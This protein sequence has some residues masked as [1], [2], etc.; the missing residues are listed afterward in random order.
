[1][2]ELSVEYR[3]ILVLREIEGWS[4]K[5]LASGLKLPPGTVMSRLNR[6]RLRLREEIGERLDEESRNEL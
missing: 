4:Y 2:A 3:E 6:A 5:Q 1:L